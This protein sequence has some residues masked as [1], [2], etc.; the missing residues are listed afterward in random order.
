MESLRSR[1]GL[2]STV[3]G[4]IFSVI[5]FVLG[6]GRPDPSGFGLA[7]LLGGVFAVSMY[8]AG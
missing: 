3:A 6:G 8:A 7:A 4:V 2:T 1:P 5:V